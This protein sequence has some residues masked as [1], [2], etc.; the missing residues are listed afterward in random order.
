MEISYPVLSV[1][2]FAVQRHTA[3][4]LRKVNDFWLNQG[5][6]RPGTL[7]IDSTGCC[8]TISRVERVRRSWFLLD[9]LDRHPWYYVNLSFGKF[10]QL[11][12]ERV[13]AVVTEVVVRKKWYRQG[14]EDQLSF[15]ARIAAANSIQEIVSGISLYGGVRHRK[16]A[17]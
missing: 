15:E 3:K 17:A 13:K 4:E 5:L 7:I 14:G 16:R 9:I 12:L 2:D 11:S 8:R 1:N 6:L 10:T